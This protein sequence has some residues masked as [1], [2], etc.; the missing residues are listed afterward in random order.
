MT[1][2]APTTDPSRQSRQILFE[3]CCGGIDDVLL[4]VK[5]NVSR[6]ELN[7]GMALGGLTPSPG[8]VREAR[9]AFPGSIIAMLRPREGGFSYSPA[10]FRQMRADAEI[11]RECGM[12]GLAVGFLTPDGS[13]DAFRCR[14]FREAYADLE[15]VFHRAIDVAADAQAALDEIVSC[16]FDRILT[17]GGHQ[18]ALEGAPRIA[19]MVEAVDGRVEVIAAGGI[20][21]DCAREVIL[22]TGCRQV[23]AALR[24]I[25]N[26]PSMHCNS[27]R[28]ART[29][30]HFGVPGAGCGAFGLASERDLQA[31]LCEIRQFNS[32]N[33]SR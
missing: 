15:L 8:L 1:G 32:G 18:T 28:P 30:L 33:K 10:E 19:S 26:D 13:V 20:R 5:S 9:R 22:K 23:H 2:S 11:L 21:A 29:Q 3:L 7:S 16:G 24:S 6:I 4:A 25:E 17:S 14:L 31:L 27:L 12:D